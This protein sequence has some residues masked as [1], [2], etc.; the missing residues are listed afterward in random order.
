MTPLAKKAAENVVDVRTSRL[1]CDALPAQRARWDALIG[2]FGPIA[3][4][5]ID[6]SDAAC[7]C[8]RVNPGSGSLRRVRERP[9]AGGRGHIVR[10]AGAT[11]RTRSAIADATRILDQLHRMLR[12]S[13]TDG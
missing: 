5:Q 9:P 7:I 4:A 12:G 2:R 11:P 3:Y 1:Y 8:F 10:I 6:G 13:L